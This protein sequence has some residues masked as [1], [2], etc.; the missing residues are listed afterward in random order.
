MRNEGLSNVPLNDK[1]EIVLELE[2]PN[3]ASEV[4]EKGALT[5]QTDDEFIK[6][7]T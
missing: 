3:S 5:I 4:A 7:A 1:S 2:E 6:L